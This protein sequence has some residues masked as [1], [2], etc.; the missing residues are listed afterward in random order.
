MYVCMCVCVCVCVCVCIRLAFFQFEIKITM[1]Y[2]NIYIFNTA[3]IEKILFLNILLVL[4]N[5]QVLPINFSLCTL[6][7]PVSQ[8]D[9]INQQ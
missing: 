3:E 5:E 9:L 6:L 2:N 1:C 4:I 8:A 7:G